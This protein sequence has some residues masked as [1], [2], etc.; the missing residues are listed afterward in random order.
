VA[1]KESI[2]GSY[3][4]ESSKDLTLEQL[5][6][7][8]AGL[9]KATKPPK[10]PSGGVNAAAQKIYSSSD[11]DLWRKR[12]IAAIFGYYKAENRT[13]TIEM[14]KATACKASSYDTFNKIPLERLK[15]LYFAFLKKKKDFESVG[16]MVV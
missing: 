15:N 6:E 8:V 4:V 11:S 9:I 1:A 5:K 10:S 3:G 16:A 13:A 12:V 7:A 2:L 14:V